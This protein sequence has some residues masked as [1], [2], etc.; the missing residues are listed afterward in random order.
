MG[1]DITAISEVEPIEIPEGIELWSNEYY[2]WEADQ[3][4]PGGVWNLYQS[5]NFP[6]QGEGLP[7]GAV[8]ATGEEFGHRAGSY[9]GYNEWRRLLARAALGMSDEEVWNKVDSGVG[10][11]EIPFGELINFS[12]ADGVIG[13]VASQKLYDDFVKYEEQIM[14]KLDRFYLKFEDYEI[15]GETYDWFKHKY[16]DWKE[17]FRIASNNGAVIFH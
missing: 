5:N 14:K 8:V 10:Y 12:D 15:D 11:N 7:N 1:L 3:A 9:S 13:P 6:E 2:D 17:A 16:K 4:L